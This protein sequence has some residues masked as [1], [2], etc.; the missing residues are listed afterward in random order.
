MRGADM[1]LAL[2]PVVSL[3]ATFTTGEPQRLP[4]F[5]GSAAHGALARALY[6][7]VCVFPRREACPGCP[8]YVRCAYPSLFETPAPP[9]MEALTSAGIRDQAP[10]PLVL[11]PEPGWTRG[12]GH[13]FRLDAGVDVPLRLTLI[14]PAIND[15]AV[16]VVAL[17]GVARRGLGVPENASASEEHPRRRTPL[18]LATVAS[19]DGRHIVYDG[20]SDTYHGA[21][22][23]VAADDNP[24][25]EIV[26]IELVTPLR[27][28][29]S[30]RLA[31]TVTPALFFRTLARRANAL[32][33]LY[34][35]GS[36]AVDETEVD[37][38]AASLV[39]EEATLRRVH[40][41]RYS[42]RQRQRMQWPGLMGRLRWRGPGLVPLWPLLRF[43]E[44][45]Q[46]GKGTALGFGRFTVGGGDVGRTN[47]C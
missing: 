28:K 5:L 11:S 45:I 18:T 15:L 40:V 32:S 16:V 24:A 9:A 42:A 1:T 35:S 19:S 10:R 12:S 26:E 46:V 47:S 22:G 27:L 37:A 36:P 29:E 2:P 44:Y 20:S 43:G 3:R 17:Q 13:P 33:L 8:L 41:R 7:T 30:G 39:V 14:G 34:G 21:S 6:R 31:D 4:P 23:A 38:Q 25:A